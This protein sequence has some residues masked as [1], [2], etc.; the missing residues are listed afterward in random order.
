MQ[1]KILEKIE[2]LFHII[3][4]VYFMNKWRKKKLK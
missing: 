2:D 3:F 4:K 1:S